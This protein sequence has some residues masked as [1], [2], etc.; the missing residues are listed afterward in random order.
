MTARPTPRA[1]RTSFTSNFNEPA[2]QIDFTDQQAA[3]WWQRRVDDALHLGA[4]GFMEDFGEQ[5]QVDMHFDNGPTGRSMHNRL[6]VL[7]YHAISRAVH[8]LRARPSRPPVLLVH[9]A[10]LIEQPGHGLLRDAEFPGDE[11][12]SSVARRARFPDDG[13]A[14]PRVWAGRM[15]S[16]PT[17]GDSSTSPTAQP[18]RSCSSAGSSGLHSRRC[19]VFTARLPPARTRPGPT[20][21]RPCAS[22]ST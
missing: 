15:A 17:S 8:E 2:A 6:P 5:V 19:S 9:P 20:T 4:E 3:D 13:H 16:R 22:T 10:G 11:T 14:Q 7:F 21:P 18:A 1:T 12:T